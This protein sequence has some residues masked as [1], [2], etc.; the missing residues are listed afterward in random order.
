MAESKD[1]ESFDCA[2]CLESFSDQLA[3][4][5]MAASGQDYCK[6]CIT[7]HFIPKAN[8][9]D[10]KI[11]N[12][13]LWNGKIPNFEQGL[14]KH[15]NQNYSFLQAINQSNKFSGQK[16]ESQK[17]LHDALAQ[18]E[19]LS[20]QL[21]EA[22]KEIQKMKSDKDK[23]SVLSVAQI[24]ELEEHIEKFRKENEKLKEKHGKQEKTNASLHAQLKTAESKV[25]QKSEEKKPQV[26]SVETQTDPIP[27]KHQSKE[28]KA[29]PVVE[30]PSTSVW[31]Y[32]PYLLKGGLV[33]VLLMVIISTIYGSVEI[34]RERVKMVSARGKWDRKNAKLNRMIRERTEEEAMSNGLLQP[35]CHNPYFTPSSSYSSLIGK[36]TPPP[37]A[38]E[39]DE[40]FDNGRT[41]CTDPVEPIESPKIIAHS[42][43]KPKTK[44]IFTP[45]DIKWN[46]YVKLRFQKE[47]RWGKENDCFDHP[48]VTGPSEEEEISCVNRRG[49][50]KARFKV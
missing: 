10:P 7:T 50:V 19:L 1:K 8:P 17:L 47:I 20:Q 21:A 30:Y 16:I 18:Q 29:A 45:E 44:I 3:P 48:K 22:K 39:L 11:G 23:A 38:E 41:E 34:E 9:V 35:F 24:K 31:D 15:Y 32:F 42:N 46:E 33:L 13:I 28:V 12:K 37:T 4:Y 43:E 27:D 49:P 40:T 6:V 25:E 5:Q 26:R 2:L 14:G 36:L